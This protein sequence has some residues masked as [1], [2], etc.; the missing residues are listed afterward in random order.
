MQAPRLHEVIQ[1][2]V[3]W[4]NRHPLARRITASQV[5]SIGEVVLPFAAA[6]PWS[7]PGVATRST[8]DALTVLPAA[9]GP[10]A[11]PDP[12]RDEIAR[13]DEVAPDG[14]LD[15]DSLADT[16]LTPAPAQPPSD[17]AEPISSMDPPDP[18]AQAEAV[19]DLATVAEPDPLAQ[20]AAAEDESPPQARVEP[21]P[22]ADTAVES[23]PAPAPA[24]DVALDLAAD[25]PLTPLPTE[26]AAPVEPVDP[27]DE[28]PIPDLADDETDRQQLLDAH[29]DALNN[30]PQP[31]AAQVD[32]QAH[33]PAADAAPSLAEVVERRAAARTA[34]AQATP[35]GARRWWA[36]LRQAL[37]GRPNGM[38][39]LQPAFNRKV[40]WPSSPSS[41]ARW[42]ERHAQGQPLA[43]DDWLHRVVET[44]PEQQTRLRRQG[45]V[46]GIEL[47][48]LT[49]AVGVGDRRIRLLVGADGSILGPRAYSPPRVASA[50]AVLLAGLLGL[51]WGLGLPGAAGPQDS[52]P[53]PALASSAGPAAASAVAMA[54]ASAASAASQAAS[55]LAM[56]AVASAV[57]GD[58]THHAGA[59]A[60]AAAAHAA[61]PALPPEAAAPASAPPVLAQAA[62]SADLQPAASAPVSRIR[63][64]LSHEAK[65][66]AKAES[67]RLRGGGGAVA[68][69]AA[70]T[71]AAGPVYAVVTQGNRER[72]VAMNQL[73]V[74]RRA[75]ARLPPPT[76]DHGELMVNQG[77]W[78]AAWW[79]FASLADAERARVM[80]AGRG[81]QAEVVEF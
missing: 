12:P 39:R 54:A 29:L 27:V 59:A 62:P 7:A 41:V 58:E 11:D 52:A 73:I 67:E 63:P 38:P 46:H 22:E 28:P 9:H 37:R 69:A 31:P 49:A 23:D 64:Q 21:E 61:G 50:S 55:A 15:L 14:N 76:P 81:L 60:S 25:A 77:E 24:A 45:Q 20:I 68:A 78:R 4:H 2:V 35:A 43:P 18:A 74:M 1:R 75:I 44:D 36:R 34:A 48:T 3:R 57:Q 10:V 17:T 32:S 40:F 51:G 26:E 71:P 6:Q 30:P 65:L 13:A 72:R 66:A 47:H 70:P 53:A 56:A 8:V 16:L 80:L 79:P 33:A 42:A 19:N 5:H